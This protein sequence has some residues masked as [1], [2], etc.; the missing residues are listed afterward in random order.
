MAT[1][2]RPGWL[3]VLGYAALTGVTIGLAAVVGWVLSGVLIGDPTLDDIGIVPIAL[4]VGAFAM[5][6]VNLRKRK[7]TV[8]R[9][10]VVMERD[11]AR[12]SLFWT[13]FEEL[14]V[15]TTPHREELV[16]G[17]GLVQPAGAGGLRRGVEAR[18]RKSGADRTVPLTTYFADWRQTELGPAVARAQARQAR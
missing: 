9:E 10:G 7:L 5:A 15:K 14:R 8:V 2:Y 13:D 17:P 4:G 3:Y 1:I 11:G 12:I 16:F 6:V 18:L